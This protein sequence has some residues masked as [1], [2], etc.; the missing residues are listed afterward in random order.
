[1]ITTAQTLCCWPRVLG[2]ANWEISWGPWNHH[3]DICNII[4]AELD[5][6]RPCIHLS[7]VHRNQSGTEG[8][9][10]GSDSLMS[11]G[12]GITIPIFSVWYMIPAPF[13][14]LLNRP[15]MARVPDSWHL[16]PWTNQLTSNFLE[17]STWCICTADDKGY[18][19]HQKNDDYTQ[20]TCMVLESN[21]LYMHR[22]RL[23]ALESPK[24]CECTA[25]LY[26]PGI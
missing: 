1:M 4:D 25:D 23:W 7:I 10:L 16:G 15:M 14:E 20:L 6:Y 12:P 5:D 8:P 9:T 11:M 21:M 18:W 13:S 3:T 24:C 17:L 26:G 22:C 19:N 2:I